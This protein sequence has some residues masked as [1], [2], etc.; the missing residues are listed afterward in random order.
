MTGSWVMP[1]SA[2]VYKIGW[3]I[4]HFVW[5]GGLAALALSVL[6]GFLKDR[7]AASRY[8]A[9]LFCLVLL[10]LAPLVTVLRISAPPVAGKGQPAGLTRTNPFHGPETQLAKES[11]LLAGPVEPAPS[12]PA[13]G[14]RSPILS[15]TPPGTIHRLTE[16]ASDW[17]TPLL[18]SFVMLWFVGVLILSIHHLAGWVAVQR[19]RKRF[20]Q[21]VSEHLEHMVA[22]LRQ[23]LGISRA[24][25]L[26]RSALIDSP[27]TIGWIK[28][29]ILLPA[30][31]L[32]GLSPRQ[33]EA[34]LAHELAHIRRHDYLVNLLQ[35]VVET[36][37]FYH[38]AVWW[39]SRR[40]R[41]ERENCCD[42]V[43]VAICGD[44]VTYV[45]ALAEMEQ[46]RTTT[47]FAM[48]AK[49]GSLLDRVRRLASLKLTESRGSRD[50]WWVG[51]PVALLVLSLA[52]M[53][54]VP[55]A[56]SAVDSEPPQGAAAVSCDPR[57]INAPSDV[58]LVTIPDDD[59][60]VLSG[61]VLGEGGNPLEGVLVDAWTWCPGDEVHTDENGRFELGGFKDQKT[62]EV[63]FS[64]EGFS[65]WHFATQP[66]GKM[67]EPVVLDDNTYFEGAVTDREGNP[68]P[69][70]LVR[71]NQ[72]PKQAEGGY[73]TTVWT[74]GRADAVGK[75]RLY[76]DPDK[77]EI[78]VSAGDRGVARLF[79]LQIAHGEAKKL[80]I[81]LQ[82]GV[83]FRA[84]TI[85]SISGK[86]VKGVR[87]WHWQ[88]KEVEGISDASGMIEIAG[89]QPGQFE[90]NVEANGYARWWSA[91]CV[92]KGQRFQKEDR[93]GGWQRNFDDLGFD[94]RSEMEPVTILIE[95]GVYITGRILDPDGNPVGGATV[96]PALT[97]TGNSIT[98][99]TRYSYETDE[100][101]RFEMWLPASK[102]RDYNLVVHDGKFQEWR[103]WANGVM[104]PIRT[105]PGQ[106]ITEVELRMNRPCG[107]KGKVV[108]NWGKPVPNHQVRAHSCDKLENR[109]Y[110]PTTRTDE[111]G[112]FEL[113]FVRAGR[114]FIQAYPFW[115]RS[116]EAPDPST[117]IVELSEGETVEEIA[118]VTLNQVGREDSGVTP[119]PPGEADPSRVVEPQARP[120]TLQSMLERTLAAELRAKLNPKFLCS[121]PLFEKRAPTAEEDALLSSIFQRHSNIGGV[122]VSLTHGSFSLIV[123]QEDEKAARLGDFIKIEDPAR[124]QLPDTGHTLGKVA[125]EMHDQEAQFV[126][127]GDLWWADVSQ[128]M[129]GTTGVTQLGFDGNTVW[130]RFGNTIETIP[131]ATVN[132]FNINLA[133]PLGLKREEGEARQDTIYLGVED[134]NGPC[135]VFS[136]QSEGCSG[137]DALYIHHY[138]FDKESLV[139]KKVE[140]FCR[141]ANAGDGPIFVFDLC[142]YS[143]EEPPGGVDAALFSPPEEGGLV[144]SPVAF[145]YA[146]ELT[147]GLS[148]GTDGNLQASYRLQYEGGSWGSG[149]N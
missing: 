118:L 128:L 39:I 67:K 114:H 80:D 88:Y 61:T 115:L 96:A 95:P 102:E 23:T 54:F 97:G 11:D 69:D 83:T 28:P 19:L 42:D 99:D 32:T 24:V 84:K 82:T 93:L 89:M 79:N 46:L 22:H 8:F 132:T 37:L 56:N 35:A 141:V 33:L 5:Q 59:P 107:V 124:L 127:I 81:Q 119:P 62:I 92:N 86:P 17:V 36:L 75:Y 78:Q 10:A 40:I 38:P 50:S 112:N 47:G 13:P 87:L 98:G 49:S 9:A 48:A 7:S 21:P 85:D 123:H 26:M 70:V 105:Q 76:A 135:H 15:D 90:F 12:R 18:P 27:V 52:A 3:T 74:E 14:R 116:E 34:I 104:A 130:F 131:A 58:G 53:Q 121:F 1:D 30:S 31:V 117:R 149:Y 51:V 120:I 43:A 94:V 108:D 122:K 142:E 101:G 29:V 138:Y 20:V 133:A 45:R 25:R 136:Q 110:D 147:I 145:P 106:E 109:Y 66:L 111:E 73:I 134:F 77:Y 16:N 144:S 65:P 64:K 60:N 126:R 91:E 4:L 125:G 137:P 63:R 44:A 41:I 100:E 72:G 55:V 148:D 6:L 143:F 71:A 129:G 140:S 139:I 57:G 2:L 68:V 103:N 146:G 113:K